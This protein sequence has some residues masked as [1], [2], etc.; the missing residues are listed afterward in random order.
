MYLLDQLY[1]CFHVIQRLKN[2]TKFDWVLVHCSPRLLCGPLVVKGLT[3]EYSEYYGVYDVIVLCVHLSFEYAVY[4]KL[5]RKLWS[6]TEIS[7]CKI[8]SIQKHSV[9][10]QYRIAMHH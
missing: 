5:C 8:L 2:W 4:S 10:Y 9:L 1:L 6:L 7:D 3:V